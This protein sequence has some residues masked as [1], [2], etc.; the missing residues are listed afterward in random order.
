MEDKNKSHLVKYHNDIQ[1]LKINHLN[2]RE[3]E[4]FIVL[5]YSV[6]NS[7]EKFVEIKYE[8]FRKKLGFLGES[9][10]TIYKF[11]DN[12]TN[13]MLLQTIRISDDKKFLKFNFFNE[14]S[15]DVE[16]GILTM[17]V[18]SKFLYLINNLIKNY[19][20]IK[21]EEWLSLKSKYSK[22]MYK[23]IREFKKIKYLK[24]SWF[25]F[26]KH[27]GLEEKT[28]KYVNDKALFYIKK[29]LPKF[30]KNF[31]FQKTKK[32]KNIEFIEFFW[33]YNFEDTIEIE[34]KQNQEKV[35]K[36]LED[37]ENYHLLVEEKEDDLE[38]DDFD[39]QF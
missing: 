12:A 35:E 3:L 19:S 16:K 28:T 22:L 21:L 1:S 30:I 39:L 29:E 36:Y 27:L 33:D 5:L 6:Q 31:R 2:K 34:V 14:F 38:D 20:Y 13:K 37:P 23:K 10:K 18:N 9:N 8:Y 26:K 15:S 17:Q 24:F 7:Q 11:L 32:E 25:E 4:F